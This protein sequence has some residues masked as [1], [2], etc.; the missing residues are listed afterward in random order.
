MKKIEKFGSYLVGKI[1]GLKE[2]LLKMKKSPMNETRKKQ[3]M[4]VEILTYKFCKVCQ[5]KLRTNP[6]FVH[7]W[8]LQC[9]KTGLTRSFS[10]H[11]AIQILQQ[12]GERNFLVNVHSSL[13]QAT[14]NC[15]ERTSAIGK[16]Q[17]LFRE[18]TPYIGVDKVLEVLKDILREAKKQ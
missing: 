15:I 18:L 13:S 1:K 4:D 11:E 9:P 3:L 2:K 6:N 8:D 12:S 7:K 5:N 16:K 17:Q 10:L 14:G